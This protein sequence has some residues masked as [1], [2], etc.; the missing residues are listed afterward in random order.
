MSKIEEEIRNYMDAAY[1]ILYIHT[2]EQGKAKEIIRNSL[3]GTPCGPVPEWDG[4][5]P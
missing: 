3:S 1:P 5:R 4:P 2:F